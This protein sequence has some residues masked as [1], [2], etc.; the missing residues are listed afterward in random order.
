M[1]LGTAEQGFKPPEQRTVFLEDMSAA[2]R[3]KSVCLLS[4]STINVNAAYT[5]SWVKQLGKYLLYECNSASIEE[6]S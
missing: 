1:L 5:T 2:E 6:Y 4:G 3:A